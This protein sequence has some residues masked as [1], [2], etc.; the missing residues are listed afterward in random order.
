MQVPPTAKHPPFVR[1]MPLAKVEVAVPSTERNPVVVAPPLMVSPPFCAPLPIVEDAR[2]SRP[3]LSVERPLTEKLP[4]PS[5]STLRHAGDAY[6]VIG[7]REPTL[8]LL[9]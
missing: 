4:L 7:V 1:L 8:P 2:E 5:S 3:P 9:P 6:E